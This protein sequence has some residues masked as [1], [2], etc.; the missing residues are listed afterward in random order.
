MNF[1]LAS[2]GIFIYIAIS[3]YQRY[4]SEVNT[5]KFNYD[6]MYKSI[7]YDDWVK[8]VTDVDLEKS[9]S[10][11]VNKYG[12]ESEIYNKVFSIV[13]S[14]EHFDK[15]FK[16]E[17]EFKNYMICTHNLM[18]ERI[19]MALNGKLLSH[20]ASFGIRSPAVYDSDVRKK[21]HINNDLMLWMDD[22]LHDHGIKYNMKFIDGACIFKYKR[23]KVDACDI[24]YNN[25][26]IGGVYFWEPIKIWL[27]IY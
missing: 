21:W 15:E 9:I 13:S 2:I 7:E 23:D 3:C 11:Y 5:A 20:D 26:V 18:I 10:E 24:K 6:Y 1:I 4:V 17:F 19:L 8:S 14:F 16:D 22:T 25:K 27:P 12:N